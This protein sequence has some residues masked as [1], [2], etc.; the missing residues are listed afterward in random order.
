MQKYVAAETI[1][2]CQEEP[3]NQGGWY[4]LKER[5]LDCLSPRQTLVYAGRPKMASSAPGDYKQFLVQ[6]KL[7]V[8]DALGTN[9]IS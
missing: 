7:L 5:I 3:Y 4:V 2:W 9:G 1:V 8:R 6:Q